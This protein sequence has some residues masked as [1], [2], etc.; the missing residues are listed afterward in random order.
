MSGK[1]VP[2]GPTGETV[3]ANIVRLRDDKN[4][5]YAELARR[6]EE[7]GRP[8]P[9]LGLRRIENGERRVDVDDLMALA[10]A[11]DVS[12]VTLLMPE[13]TTAADVVEVTGRPPE[14]AAIAWDRLRALYLRPTVT[15]DYQSFIA[16]NPPWAVHEALLA[17]N[18][19]GPP[20][21]VD[22]GDD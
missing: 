3:R 4:L 14:T 15:A 16:S 18:V 21:R 11:L 1:R 19:G 10:V 7:A 8:I 17:A 9:V 5:T 22:R 12:P 20:V 13:S 6:T 2:L